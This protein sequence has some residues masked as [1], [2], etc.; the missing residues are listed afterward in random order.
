MIVKDCH[1]MTLWEQNTRCNVT[2]INLSL[3]SLGPFLAEEGAFILS[4]PESIDS[5]GNIKSSLF[6]K[7]YLHF[8]FNFFILLAL[9]LN[10]V[11]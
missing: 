10:R 6:Y 2:S 5:R 8:L 9:M 3:L 11:K 1:F 7:Y 4:S